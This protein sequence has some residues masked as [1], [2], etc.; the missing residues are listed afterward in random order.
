MP[1][2]FVFSH[3]VSQSK[4]CFDLCKS[5]CTVQSSRKS[6]ETVYFI[7]CIIYGNCL[8][9]SIRFHSF[10]GL[11]TRILCN[12]FNWNSKYSFFDVFVNIIINWIILKIFFIKLH[13]AIWYNCIICYSIVTLIFFIQK[14]LIQ[15]LL[16]SLF[17]QC[18]FIFLVTQ[19]S[20]Y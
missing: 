12:I 15:M 16:Q 6:R 8:P 19:V 9:L 10:L 18:Y 17:L 3:S 20:C 5:S 4:R 14:T 1:Y 11:Y 7:R 13:S 2:L